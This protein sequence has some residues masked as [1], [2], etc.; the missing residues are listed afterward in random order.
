MRILV[1]KLSALGDFIQA[2]PAC[3]AVRRH[4][5]GAHVTLLTTR[6]FA[7]LAASCPYF[8]AVEIDPRPG[9]G[10][11]LEWLRLARHLRAPRYDRVYDLQTADRTGWYFRLMRRRDGG[12]LWSGIAPG[13]AFPHAN[14]DRDHQHTL[15]RQAEQLAMAGIPPADPLALPDLGWIPDGPMVPALADVPEETPLALLVPGAALHRAGKRWPPERYAEL[16]TRLADAG[17]VPVVLGTRAEAGAARAIRAA[18]PAARDLTGATTLV[19]LAR[20]GRRARLAIGNDTGPMHLLAATGCPALVLF[21]DAS[22][23]DLCAPRGPSVTIVRRP[24]LTLLGVADL[25]ETVEGDLLS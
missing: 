20:L 11:P 18:C 24:D 15:E 4:H 13:C 17:L 16:A 14:P 12:P 10:R 21:S 6:P 8:D 25:W 22:N 3:A 9:L 7:A 5:P 1:I 23:P 19:D 2:L